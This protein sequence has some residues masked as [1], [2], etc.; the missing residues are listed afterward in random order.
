MKSRPEGE[1]SGVVRTLIACDG[2]A[3]TKEWAFGKDTKNRHKFGGLRA[4]DKLRVSTT[5][6]YEWLAAQQSI[7]V[8]ES[9]SFVI[10]ERR[11]FGTVLGGSAF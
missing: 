3:T 6:R 11:V 9:S 10:D 8:L 4:T 1:Y 5:G 2:E 7:F